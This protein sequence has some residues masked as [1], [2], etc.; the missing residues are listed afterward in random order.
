MDGARQFLEHVHGLKAEN[1]V[2]RIQAQSVESIVAEPHEGVVNDEAT[3]TVA[4]R[5]HHN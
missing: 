5:P 3:H 2:H 4:L 1:G